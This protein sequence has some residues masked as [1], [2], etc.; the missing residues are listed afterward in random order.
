M[1]DR[2]IQNAESTDYP[3]WFVV[4]GEARPVLYAGPFF[5]RASA[6]KH[7]A[8]YARAYPKGAH[9]YCASGHMSE[10]YRHLCETGRVREVSDG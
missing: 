1:A 10:D 6:E 8:G 5:S 3:V 9:V 7:L 2:I 4:S